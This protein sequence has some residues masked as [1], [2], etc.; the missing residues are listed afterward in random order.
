MK[1]HYRLNKTQF[2]A[3]MFVLAMTIMVIALFIFLIVYG[4]NN[5]DKILTTYYNYL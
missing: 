1:K 4:F 3:F 5:P 2:F